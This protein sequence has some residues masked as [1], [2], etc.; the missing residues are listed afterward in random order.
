MALQLV[1]PPKHRKYPGQYDPYQYFSRRFGSATYTRIK[2]PESLGPEYDIKETVTFRRWDGEI[3]ESVILML[4]AEGKDYCFGVVDLLPLHRMELL[5][6]ALE[7]SELGGSL[8]RCKYLVLELTAHKV[9]NGGYAY[10][11]KCIAGPWQ[12][13]H[14]AGIVLATKTTSD[15]SI[16]LINSPGSGY[17]KIAA[18]LVRAGNALP[19]KLQPNPL[20]LSSAMQ[21][22]NLITRLFELSYLKRN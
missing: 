22:P 8:S 5:R 2:A 16:K 14:A 7:A 3:Q 18:S 6:D 4:D 20:P 15:R 19:H 11:A 21:Q 1:G 13:L 17:D 9:E 12:Y 10:Y